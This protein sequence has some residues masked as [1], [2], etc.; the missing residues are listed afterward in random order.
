MISMY[1]FAWWL[2]FIMISVVGYALITHVL[3]EEILYCGCHAFHVGFMDCICFL[4]LP[5]CLYACYIDSYWFQVPCRPSLIYWFIGSWVIVVP[6]MPKLYTQTYI[7]ICTLICFALYCFI[8]IHV[9]ANW[10]VSW[11][12]SLRFSTSCSVQGSQFWSWHASHIYFI[13]LYVF[14]LGHMCLYAFCIHL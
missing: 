1:L 3:C 14:S 8:L 2:G 10:E 12:V 5:I 9:R 7:Y 6:C 13:D 4:L 11:C